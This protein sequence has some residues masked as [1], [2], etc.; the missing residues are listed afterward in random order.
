ML[1][2]THME[3]GMLLPMS[4]HPSSRIVCKPWLQPSHIAAPLVSSYGYATTT[5]HAAPLVAAPLVKP[6]YYGGYGGYGAYGKYG[7]YGGYGYASPFY[8][9]YGYGVPYLKKK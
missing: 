8:G 1:F 3:L 5:V 9:G 6:V 2:P 7:S 4:P